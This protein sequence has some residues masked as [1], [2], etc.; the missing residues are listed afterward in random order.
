MSLRGLPDQVVYEMV[1]RN[2]VLGDIVDNCQIGARILSCG[3]AAEDTIHT[4]VAHMKH[5]NIQ[6]GGNLIEEWYDCLD[7]VVS[8]EL[9]PMPLLGATVTLDELPDAIEQAR[10]DTSPVRIVYKATRI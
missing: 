1:G 7:R 5:L 9:D 3:G 10:L 8:G 6:I 2:G 4:T